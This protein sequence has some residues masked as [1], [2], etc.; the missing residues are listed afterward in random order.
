L[1][2]GTDGFPTYP[3]DAYTMIQVVEQELDI[4][5]PTTELS[6]VLMQPRV[7]FEQPPREPFHWERSAVQGQ[8]GAIRKTINIATSNQNDPH[9]VVFPEYS[10]PGMDGVNL[11]DNFVCS[12][13]CPENT[14][15]IGGVDGLTS[16]QY[17]QLISMY[18]VDVHEENAPSKVETTQWVNCSFTWAKEEGGEI[19]RWVQPKIRPSLPE[20]ETPAS[21]M[22]CGKSVNVFRAKYNNDYPCRFLSL[23]CYDWIAQLQNGRAVEIVLTELNNRWVGSPSPLHWVFLLQNN[24]KPNYPEFL[25]TT[26]RFL[27]DIEPWESVGRDRAAVV[28]AANAFSEKPC[29]GKGGKGAFSGIVFAPTAPFVTNACK[30]TFCMQPQKLRQSE[31]LK[32]CKDIIFR[33]M[34]ACIHKCT[35]RVPQFVV[36]SVADRTPPVTTAE[37]FGLDENRSD[38][39]RLPDAPVPAS[40]KWVNDELDQV[41]SIAKS[42]LHHSA[43]KSPVQNSY[44]S[45]VQEV[46]VLSAGEI[47]KKIRLSSALEETD[48][49]AFISGFHSDVDEWEHGERNGL[50]HILS[51]LSILGICHSVKVT[52]GWLHAKIQTPDIILYIVAVIGATHEKCRQH[53]DRAVNVPSIDPV[54]FVTQ[55]MGNSRP[56]PQE[57]RKITDP[58]DDHAI[59]WID[60]STMLQECIDAD[61][62]E[63]LNEKLKKLFSPNEKRFV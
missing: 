52:N 19:K 28:L 49:K 16:N 20:L 60:Y 5:F 15:I 55:N 22:F 12:E 41:D 46:R 39:P 14:I 59:R 42:D 45:L 34:G 62:V 11:V 63:R 27:T 61:S 53:F 33:E 17:Q 56:S 54:I 24:E 23:L 44:D 30:P 29:S 3:N 18:D 35:I 40:I 50:I 26:K 2:Q 8:L 6:V 36:P 47:E 25:N 43:L 10:I 37:V 57:C 38:D 21:E 32:S 1:I 7:K 13:A 4:T 48:W 9:F 31:I 58:E 51:T